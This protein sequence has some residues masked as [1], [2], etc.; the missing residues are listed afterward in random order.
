M[1]NSQTEDPE[2]LELQAS[3]ERREEAFAEI[4]A[5]HRPRLRRMVRL[6]MDNEL[7]GRIDASDVIQ[8]AWMEASS[9]LEEYVESPSMPLFLWLRF[10]TRQKLL[11]LRRTH[12]DAQ[13]RDVRREISLFGGALP[14]AS[15]AALADNLMGHLTT[16]TRAARRAELQIQV[17]R[18][19]N[20]MDPVDRQI[21]A[22]RHFEQLSNT[23]TAIEM[24]MTEAAASK[25][26]IRAL[27]K[28]RGLLAPLGF[29]M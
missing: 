28:L 7:Q 18:I 20:D 1:D 4:F 29:D 10:I 17:Q 3:T 22:L 15:T 12:V 21:L 19:L 23:E 27:M 14:G 24:E 13:A 25:R 2:A 26:F 8:E 9:R 6:R 5:R 16:P 11:S